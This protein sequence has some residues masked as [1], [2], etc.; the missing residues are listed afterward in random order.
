MNR[1]EQAVEFLMRID[2]VAGILLSALAVLIWY[3]AVP[4]PV[5]ELSYF[6][7]G[8]MPR[9]CAA[10]LLIGGLS[11]LFRGVT[12]PSSEAEKLVLAVRGPFF[13]GF[14]IL[15]FAL[16]IKG[17][18]VG[19]LT[20][21]QLGLVVAGPLSIFISGFGTVE[22]RPGELIVLALGLTGLGIL[23]FVD[24]LNVALPVL[25][26]F[27]ERGIPQSWGI[28][29]PPRIAAIILLLAAGGLAW[30]FRAADN[31]HSEDMKEADQ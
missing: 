9:V 3:E 10:A 19:P 4:L 22:A 7:S 21:P 23:V 2:I 8:F 24:L 6:G 15:I 29:W 27:I 5:G 20:I 1:K 17:Y 13:V 25:P 18:A 28:D 26:S 12:Q 16:T 14:A 30:A 11:L 31:S